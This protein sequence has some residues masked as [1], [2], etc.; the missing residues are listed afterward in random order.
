MPARTMY[1]LRCEFQPSLNWRQFDGCSGMENG[2]P[3]AD[4]L[5]DQ[6]NNGPPQADT[7]SGWRT[8]T[9]CALVPDRLWRGRCF[10]C[11]F[12]I[13]NRSEGLWIP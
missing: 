8:T 12:N 10:I 2:P 9:T 5:F 1:P 3:Q 4:K 6:K 13:L 11:P 7:P